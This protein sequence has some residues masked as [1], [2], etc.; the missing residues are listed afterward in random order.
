MRYYLKLLLFT[1]IWILFTDAVLF[2]QDND[3]VDT[4]VVM[5]R[6]NNLK[7]MLDRLLVD[8]NHSSIQKVITQGGA[9][10]EPLIAE[11]LRLKSSGEQLLAEKEYMQA[12]MTLQSALDHVFQAIRSEDG[13]DESVDALSVRL[14]EDI[15]VNDTFIEAASRVVAG[16]PNKDALELLTMAKET[17]DSAD[18]KAAK[19]ELEAAIEELEHSTHLAQQAVISVRNGM[20]IERGQ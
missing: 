19:G 4:Q 14:A 6:A 10:S 15:T 1:S 11:A 2:A 16:E 7:S 20:V 17:R 13:M 9:S 5:E 3:A 18:E 8:T 12:A